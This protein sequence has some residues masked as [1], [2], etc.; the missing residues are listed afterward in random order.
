MFFFSARCDVSAPKGARI[1]SPPQKHRMTPRGTAKIPQIMRCVDSPPQLRA[2]PLTYPPQALGA[3]SVAVHMAQAVRQK[4]VTAAKVDKEL[5]AEQPDLVARVKVI[6]E[7]LSGLLDVEGSSPHVSSL[8]LSAREQLKASL[9]LIEG[10]S[11]PLAK[12]AY[13]KLF[14]NQ[15]KQRAKMRAHLKVTVDR[16]VMTAHT[17]TL[18]TKIK[19][20]QDGRGAAAESDD[21]PETSSHNSTTSSVSTP[22]IAA[23]PAGSATERF[24]TVALGFA[25][26]AATTWPDFKHR[27]EAAMTSAGGALDLS[28]VP[29]STRDAFWD[30]LKC[31]LMPNAGEVVTLYALEDFVQTCGSTESGVEAA[32]EKFLSGQEQEVDSTGDETSRIVA[33]EAGGDD[34]R[35]RKLLWIDDR[36]ENNED[37][38]SKAMQVSRAHQ[39]CT[40]RGYIP[41]ARDAC[42]PVFFLVFFIP[43]KSDEDSLTQVLLL[44][45]A[46]NSHFFPP[47]PPPENFARVC[48]LAWTSNAR[49]LSERDTRSSSAI[50]ATLQR[51]SSAAPRPSAS[52]RTMCKKS[53][54]SATRSRRQ[55]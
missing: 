11:K 26:A 48:R 38:V 45:M 8:V 30:D 18:S 32:L 47:P 13:A 31:A 23:C 3:A 2:A 49:A 43:S 34:V 4:F 39:V 51:S 44:L 28:G 29:T 10:L 21:Q 46:T 36:P 1:L 5:A 20:G 22:T 35:P 7:A 55:S 17:L 25:D 53:R 6:E 27:L 41:P 15:N 42:R 24:W 33:E 12:D 40:L 14:K 52:S 54:M 50:C 37:I 9:L 16:L 19:S